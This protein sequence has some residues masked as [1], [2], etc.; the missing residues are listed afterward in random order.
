[1]G[2]HWF[3]QFSLLHGA[4]GVIFYFWGIS[5][6]W[7]TIIHILFEIIE[8]TSCG[9]KIINY[10]TWWPGGKDFAD[11]WINRLGD[12]ISGALGWWIASFID[13]SMGSLN[14]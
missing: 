8:N 14:H 3:D 2:T 5:F 7:W 13:K 9:M 10:F 12:L 1:M 6:W 4:V 11:A